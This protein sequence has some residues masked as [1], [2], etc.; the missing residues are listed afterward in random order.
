[1][2]RPSRIRSLTVAGAAILLAVMSTPA[3]AHEPWDD[4]SVPPPPP[5]S[6]AD[7]YSGNMHLLSTAAHTGGVNSDLAFSGDLVFAGHYGGFRIID[8]S[9][10]GTPVELADVHCNGPQGDVS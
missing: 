1:M 3:Q 9:G 6:P 7:G 8:I 5:S 10:P 4:G 2:R